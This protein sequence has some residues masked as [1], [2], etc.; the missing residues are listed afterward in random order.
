MAERF[1]SEAL[2]PLTAGADTKRMAA[3]EPGLPER[4]R[5]RNLELE[6]HQVLRCWKSTGPCRHGSGE[7]F[8][9]RHW[10]E[11]LSDRGRLKI[12]FER[13]PR[14][15]SQGPRWWLYSLTSEDDHETG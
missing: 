8:V 14:R 3:G 7:H 9:R 4:F 15:G 5:W 1:I 2:K 13:Q 12:Y 6:V 11:V 10:F